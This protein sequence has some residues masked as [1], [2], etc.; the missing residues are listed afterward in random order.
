MKLLDSVNR[1]LF[2]LR[3]QKNDSKLGK[4]LVVST[5]G[6]GDTLLST[7]AIKSLRNSFSE[8]KIIF[9]VNKKFSDLFRNY[10]HVNSIWEYSGGYI[11]LLSI[12]I[13]CKIEKL[14]THNR[15][16]K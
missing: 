13:K 5:T 12:I 11:N 15:P 16:T 10:K 4:V 9:L 8:E 1:L 14:H 2:S 3:R 6:F 7:P